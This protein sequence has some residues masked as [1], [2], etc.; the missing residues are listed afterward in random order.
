MAK[1]RTCKHCEGE[2]FELRT[3]AGDVITW[4]H[5]SGHQDTWFCPTCDWGVPEERV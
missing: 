5:A 1:T 4:T 3:E 2:E